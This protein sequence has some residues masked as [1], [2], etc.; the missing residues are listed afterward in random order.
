LVEKMLLTQLDTQAADDR[1]SRNLAMFA[2]VML[3][4][5]PESFYLPWQEGHIS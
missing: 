2:E 3:S 4:F 1:H 5:G